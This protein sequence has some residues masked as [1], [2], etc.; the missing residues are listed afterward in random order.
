MHFTLLGQAE[1]LHDLIPMELEEP[2]S[3]SAQDHS[4]SMYAGDMWEFLQQA[5]LRNMMTNKS[6]RQ[7]HCKVSKQIHP[8]GRLMMSVN[9]LKGLSTH[10]RRNVA[11]LPTYIKLLY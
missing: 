3:D 7:G 8:C 10:V 5:C 9:L 6:M 4:E 2:V 1:M 11:I